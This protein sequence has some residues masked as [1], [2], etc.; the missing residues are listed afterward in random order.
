MAARERAAALRVSPR[1]MAHFDGCPHKG[2]EDDDYSK[3]GS[4]D[5][6]GAWQVLAN[7]ERIESVTAEGKLLIAESRCSTCVE[8]G[9][10]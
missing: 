4:I 10:W 8:H 2:D 7:K 9:P 5:E 6:P 3:W 1:G